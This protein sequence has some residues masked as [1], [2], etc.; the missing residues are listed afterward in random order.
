MIILKII[1]LLILGVITIILFRKF[2][3]NNS[4]EY[5]MARKHN[6]KEVC[7][8]KSR[9]EKLKNDKFDV[10]IIGGGI[11]GAGCALDSA[12]RG[13]K[14]AL[15]ERFDFGAETSSKSTKLLHGGLR[16][17]LKAFSEFS[18]DQLLL[19]T[20]GLKERKLII[21]MAPYLTSTIKVLIPVYDTF[22][23]PYYFVM[24][25][26]YDWLS[27][28][29]T[30]GRSYL[31]S[32]NQTLIYYGNLPKRNLKGSIAYYDGMMNDGRMN[33]IVAKTA[34]RH[35]AIISNYIEFKEFKKNEAGNIEC[36]I[37]EDL[38]THDKFEI[39]S[40]V[41]ISA[42]GCFTDILRSQSNHSITKSIVGSSGTHIVL[43][44]QFG[45]ENVGLVDTNTNDK[46]IAFILPW[47]GLKLVGATEVKS[48]IKATMCPEKKEIEFLINEAQKYSLEKI[49]FK[50][51]KAAWSAIRP[52]LTSNECDNTE[53]IVRNHCIF[54]DKNG[55]ISV[56]GGKWTTFRKMAEETINL[57][58][59][60]YNIKPL[61]GCVTTKLKLEGSKNYSRDIY[62]RLARILDIDLEYAKHLA[63]L[64]GSKAETLQGYLH[65]YPEILS[66]KYLFRAAEAIYC[67]ENEYAC[68]SLDIINNRFEVGYYDVEEAYKMKLKLD[69]ILEKYYTS[70]GEKYLY[71]KEYSDKILKSLGL[72]IIFNPE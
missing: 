31:L 9:L 11:T 43:D 61:N 46:R 6:L 44:S 24:G 21:K 41:Y 38:L 18:F 3:S 37:C 8:R 53:A 45:P 40:K 36:A 67:L 17:L 10:L 19:V 70:K 25:K 47:K 12:T 2:K 29:E 68:T 57:A 59:K 23:I 15:I 33:V 71:D 35:G 30:L 50:N 56:T 62:F 60:R 54:D 72:G 49:E 64:Y 13:L 7:S 48:E 20:R 4:Y 22:K 32:K 27:C 42:T 34:S 65:K 51:V 26:L 28:G 14:T 5:A 1:S 58:I 63:S 16:Y 55:L 66:E 52:L 39:V 69:Q